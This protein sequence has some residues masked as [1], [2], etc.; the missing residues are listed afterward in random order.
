M[1]VGPSLS[2]ARQPGQPF[3]DERLEAYMRCRAAGNSIVSASKE[4]GLAKSSAQKVEASEA[5]KERLAEY[6]QNTRRFTEIS[7]AALMDKLA[8]NADEAATA[9]DF[10][11]SNQAIG[12]LLDLVKRDAAKV[13]AALATTGMRDRDKAVRTG[14][15]EAL[16][17]M[18]IEEVT[19]TT[20][21]EVT[22]DGESDD[23]ES[24]LPE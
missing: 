15:R 12:M 10:K 4:A 11:A 19:D 14:R 3:E 23:A 16:R 22:G 6:K 9:G 21:E 17:S 13:G 7:V 18:T 8:R 5:Y 20:G 1:P 2:Y 24:G